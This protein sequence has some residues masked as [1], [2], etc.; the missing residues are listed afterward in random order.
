VFDQP[1]KWAIT[2]KLEDWAMR[3]EEKACA[4]LISYLNKIR[5]SFEARTQPVACGHRE[6]LHNGIALSISRSKK[7]VYFYMCTNSWYFAEGV[8][9]SDSQRLGTIPR[10][11]DLDT[12]LELVLQAIK[13]LENGIVDPNGK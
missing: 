9:L 7:E 8:I 1:K 4:P 3:K 6:E 2:Q 12:A 11:N 13:Y 10:T 5:P